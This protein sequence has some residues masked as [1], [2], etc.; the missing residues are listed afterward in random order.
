MKKN[1]ST[2]FLRF[3]F[4]SFYEKD[5]GVRYISVNLYILLLKLFFYLM[6]YMT[7]TNEWADQ[8]NGTSLYIS[9]PL[10]YGCQEFDEI[11]IQNRFLLFLILFLYFNY[12]FSLKYVFYK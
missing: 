10:E 1:V 12:L 11:F 8:S 3:S 6:I 4:N 7:L 5:I 9:K 2:A